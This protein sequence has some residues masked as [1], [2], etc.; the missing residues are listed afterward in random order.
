MKKIELVLDEAQK[1]NDTMECVNDISLKIKE[2]C[3]VLK[4]E[5]QKCKEDISPEEFVERIKKDPRFNEFLK[6]NPKF[7]FLNLKLVKKEFWADLTIEKVLQILRKNSKFDFLN[8]KEVK[9]V[10]FN[11]KLEFLFIEKLLQNLGKN[12]NINLEV[13]CFFFWGAGI[14]I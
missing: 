11:L 9:K 2:E 6:N 13:G 14:Y 1:I 3:R 7:D 12:S 4:A 5:F 8:F 10:F